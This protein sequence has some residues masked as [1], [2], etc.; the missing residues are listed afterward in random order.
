MKREIYNEVKGEI[1]AY[2]ENSLSEFEKNIGHYCGLAAVA[3]GKPDFSA[4]DAKRYYS[5]LKYRMDEI[6]FKKTR[7]ILD[8]KFA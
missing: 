5:G 7:D 4:E 6:A 3:L 1:F 8:G 2:Y